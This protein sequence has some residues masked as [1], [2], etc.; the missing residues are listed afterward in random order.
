MDN[1]VQSYS[2][3]TLPKVA[4]SAQVEVLASS[5]FQELHEH[6]L[7]KRKRPVA[8]VTMARQQTPRNRPHM[9]SSYRKPEESGIDS[10]TLLVQLHI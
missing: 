10:S 1:R 6:A 4:K 7:L 5:M 2:P 8:L 9:L 3:D